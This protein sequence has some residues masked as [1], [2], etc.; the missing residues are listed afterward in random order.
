MGAGAWYFQV[1]GQE[2]KEAPEPR[3]RAAVETAVHTL[4]LQD[5]QV[6]IL[7]QGSV[8]AQNETGITAGVS[9]RVMSI[10]PGFEAGAFFR[11][12]D[13]LLRLD[14]ADLK[15][16]VAS[17]EAALARAESDLLQEDSRAR[18]A[19]LNWQD[20]GYSEEPTDLV[21]R[22]PQ[23]KQAE[24]S[25]K[26]AQ[27]NLEQAERSLKRATVRAPYNGRTIERS[28]SIGQSINQATSLGTVFSTDSAEVRLPL[29][30]I[31][32]DSIALPETSE[33]A[34]LPVTLSVMRGDI[35]Y[36]R[37]ASVVRTEGVLDEV[38]KELFVIAIVED[39]FG[40]ESDVEPLRIGQPVRAKILGNVIENVFVIER[41]FLRSLDEIIII[42]AETQTIQRRIVQPVWSTADILV[43]RD[44]LEPGEL[45]AISLLTYAPEGGK[46]TIIELNDALP[47]NAA[48]PVK[49]PPGV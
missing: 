28:V 14:D 26:S 37:N 8:Q 16:A 2:E 45:M 5:Y 34:P 7:T 22:K 47:V 18:Q 42:E 1:S 33:D 38:T 44:G 3:K 31:Q 4:E 35:S 9:G 49:V 43:I 32:L 17:A 21:L 24:A 13:I 12:G 48:T 10:D 23:M 20:L 41:Q 6:E 11:K 36:E 29:N 39:P 30:A 27:A 19:L 46:V 15:S 25:V 40:L